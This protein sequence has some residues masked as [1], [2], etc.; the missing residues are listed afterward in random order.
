MAY[1]KQ[2][3]V[4][5][6]TDDKFQFFT[7]LH[8]KELES[9]KQ[10]D[11][12]A[13]G[14][15]Y[16]FILKNQRE[17]E[18]EFNHLFYILNKQKN[19]D[20]EKNIAFWKYCYYCS[21][22]LEAF[23][24]A[25]SQHAKVEKDRENKQKIMDRILKKAK[26]DKKDEEEFIESLRK[27]Y[28]N[29]FRNL[30]TAPAHLS[31][32]RDYVAY[33]NLC[34]VYWVFCRLTL[35]SGFT[36]AKE[37][38]LLEKLDAI[39]GTHTDADKIIDFIKAPN[40]LLNYFSVGLFLMRFAID[41]GYLVQ[42]TWFPTDLEKKDKTTALERFKYEFYK[43]HCNFANDLVWATV[44]FITNFNHITNIPDPTAGYITAIFLGF[45]VCL[46]LYKCHL[47]KQ[48]YL[49]K[50]EQYETELREYTLH[51]EKF[52]GMDI[53]RHKE[54]LE[55]QLNELEINWQTKE[56]TFYFNAAAASL[57]MIGF[58][59]SLLLTGPGIPVACFF[60]CTLAVAM[61]L[62]SDS[63]SKL[64]EKSLRLDEA[65][66]TRKDLQLALN[67]YEAARNDFIFTMIK[68]TVMPTLLIAT[69][70]VCWPAAI[71]LTVVYL[72][73]EIYH[74]HDQHNSTKAPLAL[75]G[76][77]NDSPIKESQEKEYY[78]EE[79]DETEINC[80]FP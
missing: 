51:P 66:N 61:Y 36:L 60:V 7:Q 13:S 75:E 76:P 53:K 16:S 34:R 43:R 72:G 58:S 17:L 1:S 42:H 25:Y 56:G 44:N 54:M 33:V 57:L 59:A 52:Q 6:F 26:Q 67:E 49:L 31:R 20:D 18:A 63:Y 3:E 5:T 4:F 55:L 70:A 37:L 27:S 35:T 40:G 45:D 39:L 29:G 2:N 19:D 80:C 24:L 41:F 32:I 22:L 62:S 30:F 73:Y 78:V 46:T 47:A 21:S 23:H 77:G 38:Q 8:N 11:D 12:R 9:F 15:S 74:A 14:V 10:I 79:I 65:K 28:I 48:E 69:F 68:N 71:A 50:K 64:H